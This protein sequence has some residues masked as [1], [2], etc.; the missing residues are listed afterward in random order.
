MQSAQ[1]GT[2]YPKNIPQISELSATMLL[3][4]MPVLYKQDLTKEAT[5]A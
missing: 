2:T 4:L 5:P 3:Q 1:S